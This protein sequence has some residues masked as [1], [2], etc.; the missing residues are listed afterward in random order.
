MTSDFC[1]LTSAAALFT[2]VAFCSRPLA[3]REP[4]L[5]GFLGLAGYYRKFVKKIGIVAMPLTEL[6]KK[7]VLFMWTSVHDEAFST[8]IQSLVSA[9]VLALPDFSR[10]FVIETD[11]LSLGIGAILL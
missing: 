8:L 1:A 10:Q 4:L 3:R 11:P 6:L 9:P 5:R 2:T 7:G